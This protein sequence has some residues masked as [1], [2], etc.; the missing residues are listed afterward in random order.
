[1]DL[2]AHLSVEEY[3]ATSHR[4]LVAMQQQVWDGSDA[5][6]RNAERFAVEVFEPVRTLL[7][8]PLHINS[9]FRCA[10]LNDAVGGR[11]TSRHVLGLAADVVPVGMTLR[12]AMRRIFDALDHGGLTTVDEAIQ[13]MT[14]IHL[15]GCPEGATPRRLLLASSDGVSFTPWR[16]A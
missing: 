12:D 5:V 1:M 10:R 4:D 7:G 6:R 3:L 13:E 16:A 14:W 8:V 11:P 2:S 15:Q 9:G